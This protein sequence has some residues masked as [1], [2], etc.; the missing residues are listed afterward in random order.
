MYED[1]LHAAITVNRHAL[2]EAEERDRERAAGKIR[3]PLHGIPIALKD[4]VLTDD[5][6]TTGGALA[7][8]GYVPP[9]EATLTT[10]LRA[11]GAIII[12]K[13]G[14][15]ELANWVA[16]DPT[17]MP[18]NYNAVGGFGY[19]PYDPRPDPREATFDGRPALQTGGSSSGIGT[20]ASFW[21]ANVGTDTGGSVISPSN[22]NMLVGIRPTIGRIRRMSHCSGMRSSGRA[23]IAGMVCAR[24]LKSVTATAKAISLSSASVTPA[25]RSA[26]QASCAA[27]GPVRDWDR[28]KATVASVRGGMFSPRAS[29]SSVRSMRSWLMPC[30]HIMARTAE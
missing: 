14:L 10:N 5:L 19:N 20:A 24:L 22:A 6:P 12:A 15:T 23:G 13:T 17:P 25:A 30:A 11:S 18:G 2:E 27:G 1:K 29:A 16:G 4:N 26:V 8:A 7:F 21:A 3:G 28:P 9:Y